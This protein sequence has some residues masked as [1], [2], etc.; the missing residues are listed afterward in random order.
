[1]TGWTTSYSVGLMSEQPLGRLTCALLRRT[2]GLHGPSRFRALPGPALTL[3]PFHDGFTPLLALIICLG[4]HLGPTRF[5]PSPQLGH[6]PALFL[7]AP[8]LLTLC[9]WPFSPGT[10]RRGPL[11]SPTFKNTQAH[12]RVAATP[13]SDQ[14]RTIDTNPDSGAASQNHARG[15]N[16]ANSPTSPNFPTKPAELRHN[17]HLHTT[18]QQPTPQL[19]PPRAGPH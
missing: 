14:N 9:R 3:D 13:H 6:L 8:T 17:P 4:A 1:M 18:S 5:G 15:Q 10:S 2:S 12:T 16:R 11:Y 7:G 19:S